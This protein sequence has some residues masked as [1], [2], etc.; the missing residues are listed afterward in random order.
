MQFQRQAAGLEEKTIHSP[1]YSFT[2]TGSQGMT[3]A[4]SSATAKS[5]TR[6]TKYRRLPTG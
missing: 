1:A 3:L 4:V 5:S 6:K 2:L